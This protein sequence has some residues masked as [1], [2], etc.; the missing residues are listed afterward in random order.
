M[1]LWAEGFDDGAM[2]GTPAA[3]TNNPVF[4]P[5]VESVAQRSGPYGLQCFASSPSFAS[6]YYQ[7]TIPNTVTG[8]L[9]CAVQMDQLYATPAWTNDAFIKF[10]GNSD[11]HLELVIRMDGHFEVNGPGGSLGTGTFVYT[12][13]SWVGLACKWTIA[14]SGSFEL[15]VNGSTTPDI[16]VS[17]VDTKA[18]TLYPY[19]SLIQFGW[20]DPESGQKLYW[21]DDIVIQNTTAPVTD[22]LGDPSLRYLRPN[23][24]GDISQ[25]VIGGT[26]PAGTDWQSV[27]EVPP[28]DGVTLIETQTSGDRTNFEMENLSD[29][30]GTVFAVVGLARLRKEAAGTRTV[31]QTLKLNTTTVSGD[32]HALSTSWSTYQYVYYTDPEGNT[33]TGTNVNL[34]KAGVRLSS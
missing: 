30:T 14:D 4:Y 13:Y 27:N 22:W 18:G 17:S 25:W 11:V 23:A 8:Y 34:L 15:R 20:I 26:A 24:S 33:W 1:I 6:S 21:F 3:W 7:V 5:T 31:Q 19:V 12:P 32:H 9:Y 28:D 2:R 10:L 29:T 16:A